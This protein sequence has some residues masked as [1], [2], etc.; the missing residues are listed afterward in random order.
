MFSITPT[1][2]TSFSSELITRLILS[3]HSKI[4]VSSFCVLQAFVRLFGDESDS[5]D[6]ILQCRLFAFLGL[7]L[8]VAIMFHF[9]TLK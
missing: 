7:S 9:P 2:F 8:S 3:K 5:R 6:E 1:I 4:V